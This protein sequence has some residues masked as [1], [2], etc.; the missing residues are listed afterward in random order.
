MCRKFFHIFI[1]IIAVTIYVN[2]QQNPQCEFSKFKPFIL[3]NLP[4]G[5]TVKEVQPNYP[6]SA[7]AVRAR[8]QVVVIVL[9][10]KKGNV[11][12][13]CSNAGHPLLRPASIKAAYKWKFKRNLGFVGA[14]SRCYQTYLLF[15]FK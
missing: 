1:F 13:A 12:K 7:K 9:V 11:I 2:A 15:D 5:K 10:D 4:P 14:S 8:G 6:E 3:L